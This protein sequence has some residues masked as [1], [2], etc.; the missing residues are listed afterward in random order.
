MPIS[1]VLS[2]YVGRVFLSS[3]LAALAGLLAVVALFDLI[4]LMR[5]AAG[6]Q[7][8]AFG[9][10]ATITA[11][12]L[13]FLA[14]EIL[15][16]AILLG[17]LFCFWRLTRSSELIVARAAG[18]S[19]WQFL[20]LPVLAA[21]ALGA[22]A[23]TALSPVS[24]SMLARAERLDSALL[25]GGAGVLGLAGGG[26]WVRQP[27]S[28]VPGGGWAIFRGRRVQ[29][30]GATLRL[31]DVSVFRLDRDD[32]FHSRIEAAEAVLEPGRWVL[33][34]AVSVAVERPREPLPEVTIPTELTVERLQESLA[35]PDTLSF[36]A[37]PRFIALLEQA[38]FSS[39][40]HR[41]RYQALLALPLLAGVMVLVAA[42]FS[43]R[44]AR[45]GGVALAIAAGVGAGVA[46]FVLTK[47]VGEFGGSGAIPV[48]LAAWTPSA[49]GLA[50]AVAMLL[51]LEDG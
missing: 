45:R 30:A 20:A 23:T 50:L 29:L 2:A 8:V 12:R 51:H 43:M 4:E 16:F 14:I 15:P 28:S 25:R 42:G 21:V 44:P 38:G 36:W 34:G 46:L 18:V 26:I 17:G 40:K 19:A 47:V 39:L 10:L 11:L 32:R 49:V 24:A 33:R 3:T 35:P 7:E 22:F 27:D 31:A 48:A 41:L 9:D 6:R 13:P 5:R 37:L 1:R